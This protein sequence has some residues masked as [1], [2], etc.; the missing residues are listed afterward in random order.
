MKK[1][2]EAGVKALLA[3]DNTLSDQN[4]EKALA[5]LAGRTEPIQPEGLKQGAVAQ[6]IS[7]TRQTIAS[8]EKRGL[9]HA[10]EL[11]PGGPKRYNR[12]EILG[13]ICHS[14]GVK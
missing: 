2:I 10:V 12:K 11:W 13:L 8:M 5:I 7:V 4:R 3:Q 9:L 14:G 1:T 6:M